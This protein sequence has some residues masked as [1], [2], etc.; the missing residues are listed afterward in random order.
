[1]K[2]KIGDLVIQIITVMIGVF[3][4]FIVSS[5]SE[6]SKEQQQA[7]QLLATISS[8]VQ[9]NQSRI[10]NVIDYHKMLRDTTRYYLQQREL[11][12]FKPTFFRGLNTLTLSNSAF[13]TGTQT[14]LIN[15]IPL[16][17]L[18]ALNNVYTKQRAYEN[19]TNILLTGLMSMDFNMNP[20]SARKMLMFLSVS[21]T[22]IV[23]K[24]EQLL[25]SYQSA[26]EVMKANDD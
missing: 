13:E 17:Q 11:S 22:D 9:T 12:Q 3:L 23:I 6:N 7:N 20:E 19:F 26:Q 21:M 24:E 16:E 14:G 4:G 5:W 18:Q 1:M 2:N 10:V 8:E 15:N 25:Q